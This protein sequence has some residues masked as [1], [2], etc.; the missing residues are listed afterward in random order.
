MNNT[1]LLTEIKE[2]NLAYLLLA[3]QMLKEDRAAAIYRLGIAA[4]VAD[5]LERLA[6]SQVARIAP[7]GTLMFR[8]RCDERSVLE[9][10][11]DRHTAPALAQTHA[12]ILMAG[13]APEPVA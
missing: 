11:A 9:L 10:L 13:R 7:S 8:M 3:Q 2:A 1:E 5:I 6:P 12:A 4:D